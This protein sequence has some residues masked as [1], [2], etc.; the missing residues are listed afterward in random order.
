MIEIAQETFNQ[1]FSSTEKMLQKMMS[2]PRTKLLIW[3]NTTIIKAYKKA[4]EGAR[5][6]DVN[7]GKV[8][9]YH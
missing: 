5:T 3:L 7:L 6:L 9:F 8:A 1:V 2:N 4:D